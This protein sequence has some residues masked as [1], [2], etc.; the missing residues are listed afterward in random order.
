VTSAP[1][2]GTPGH[3]M[4]SRLRSTGPPA[5]QAPETA[6]QWRSQPEPADTV[7]DEL[8]A[9]G[10]S[11]CPPAWTVCPPAW[12]VCPGTGICGGRC[13]RVGRGS[14]FCVVFSVQATCRRPK[15][16]LRP[17]WVAGASFSVFSVFSVVFGGRVLCPANVTFGHEDWRSEAGQ[18]ALGGC[19]VWS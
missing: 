5:A 14:S 12:T 9:G 16:R 3:P 18:W 2:Y 15:C 4:A 7:S 19:S 13:Q 11:R 8:S 10:E 17:R 6:R 1:D